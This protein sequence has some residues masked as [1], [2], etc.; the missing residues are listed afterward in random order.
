MGLLWNE[1]KKTMQ[2]RSAYFYAAMAMACS[3]LLAW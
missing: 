2:K 3:L 1:M